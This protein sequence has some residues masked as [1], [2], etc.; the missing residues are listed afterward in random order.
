MS[1]ADRDRLQA[2]IIR[3]RIRGREIR[4]V[5]I[6]GLRALVEYAPDR[7]AST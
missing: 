6:G 7:P 2:I 3:A 5:L 1:D 4:M